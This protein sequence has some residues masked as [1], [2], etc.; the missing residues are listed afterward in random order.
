MK[1]SFETYALTES[2]PFG[3]EPLCCGICSFPIN[4]ALVAMR[5]NYLLY[6]SN[7]TRQYEW[8]ISTDLAPVGIALNENYAA[9][10]T[11]HGYVFI[12]PIRVFQNEIYREAWKRFIRSDFY[13]ILEKPQ[14]TGDK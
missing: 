13:K 6:I 3:V 7:T 14:Y 9:I 12:I 11:G 10:I 2:L 8:F 1:N 4:Q 5:E